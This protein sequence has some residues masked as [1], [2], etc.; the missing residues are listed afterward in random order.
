MIGIVGQLKVNYT[1]DGK[2]YEEIIDPQNSAEFSLKHC[3]FVKFKI[4]EVTYIEDTIYGLV[5]SMIAPLE[6]DEE[7]VVSDRTVEFDV[8]GYNVSGSFSLCF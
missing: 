4:E 5:I 1:T 8:K 3:A 7:Y 6:K 2:R